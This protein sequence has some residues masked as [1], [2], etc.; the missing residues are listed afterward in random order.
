MPVPSSISDLST[1]PSLNSPAGTESPS[2]VDDYLRT[3]AAFIRQV[4][5]KATGTVKAA[6]LA[7]TGGSALVGYGAST[8]QATL[9]THDSKLANVEGNLNFTTLP[10]ATLPVGNADLLLIRQGASNK[11]VDVSV[12]RSEFA[13]DAVAA[14]DQ[15]VTAKNAAEAARDAAQLSAGVY[16]NTADGLAATTSGKYFSVPSATNSEYLILYKNSSGAADEVKRYPSVAA[17]TYPRPVLETVGTGLL[18][19]GVQI[20]GSLITTV[21]APS[22]ADGFVETLS[23][24]VTTAGYVRFYVY[25]LISGTSY[26]ISNVLNFKV[27]AGLN[28]FA[29]PADFD[30][31]RLP[32]G[33]RIGGTVLSGGVNIMSNSATANGSAR[34]FLASESTYVGATATLQAVTN[35]DDVRVPSVKYTIV[36][37]DSIEQKNIKKIN[38]LSS[39]LLISAQELASVRRGKKSLNRQF[40]KGATT[41]SGWTLNGWT[42]NNGLV[43]PA[44]PGDSTHARWDVYDNC[45]Y[46]SIYAKFLV[47]DATTSRFGIYTEPSQTSYGGSVQVD[48]ATSK[49]T[50]YYANGGAFTSLT[51]STGKTVSIPALVSGRE[52]LMTVRKLGLDT[53]IEWRDCIT[54]TVT[55][56]LSKFSAA[57]HDNFRGKP[58]VVY[59][60]GAANGVTVKYF[61]ASAAFDN[62]KIVVLGD[63]NSWGG[64]IGPSSSSHKPEEWKKAWSYLLDAERGRGDV[65]I[66]SRG[67]ETSVTLNSLKDVHVNLWNPDFWVIAIGTNDTD[68]ATWRTNVATLI[69]ACEA[70]GGQV[71]L[72]TV[73]PKSTAS[74]LVDSMNADILNGYFGSYP[75]IDFASALSA[76]NDRVNYNSAF[77]VDTIHFNVDGHAAVFNRIKCDA[78][79]LLRS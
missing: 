34:N 24:N 26:R 51:A 49:M 44:T 65:L 75:V 28:T 41:P 27:A 22:S 66:G 72:C 78:P 19:A 40:F 9:Q 30:Y 56:L 45:Q 7:A 18:D 2:T 62:P 37:P 11:K 8:V 33:S 13:T 35:S 20:A 73:P 61:E 53:L 54:G 36:H 69:S 67:G 14:K 74:T 1:T 77:Y 64:S 50:M 60:A 57:T 29:A 21:A 63:S 38:E 3:H 32:P 46:G 15:A 42:V 70:R 4:D 76:S 31:F 39:G 47:T 5:N 59:T 79:Y 58:G 25:E 12:I 16:A 23:F 52:Y 48:A 17:L 10:A 55:Q 71:V 6:D 68:L 43:A